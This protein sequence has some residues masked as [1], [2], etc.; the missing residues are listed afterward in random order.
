MEETLFLGEIKGDTYQSERHCTIFSH[1]LKLYITRCHIHALNVTKSIITVE[2]E[3]GAK[4]QVG[5]CP[6]STWKSYYHVKNG[7]GYR[8]KA[9]PYYI[10]SLNIEGFENEDIPLFRDDQCDNGQ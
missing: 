7:A 5:V 2:D 3:I 9:G 10:N 8:Y 4:H 6:A 1:K